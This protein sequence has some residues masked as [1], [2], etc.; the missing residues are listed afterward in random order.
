[1]TEVSLDP[2]RLALVW[3]KAMRL[4]EMYGPQIDRFLGFLA[5]LNE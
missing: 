4:R 3:A 2:D 5:A 1:M